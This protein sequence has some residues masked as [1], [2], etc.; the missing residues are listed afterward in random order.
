M[1]RLVGQT[2]PEERSPEGTRAC[3]SKARSGALLR[4]VIP[5]VSFLLLDNPQDEKEEVKNHLGLH[6]K[7]VYNCVDSEKFKPEGEKEDI[8]LT[9]GAVKKETWKRKGIDVFLDVADMFFYNNSEISCF[10]L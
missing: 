1:G 3:K 2:C 8:V 9:V 10:S 5:V 6:S 4:E 7:M